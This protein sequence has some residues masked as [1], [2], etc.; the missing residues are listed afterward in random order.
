MMNLI[1]Q[2]DLLL[3]VVDLQT[4][5][6]QQLED[7]MAILAEHRL[8]PAHHRDQHPDS[9]RL[10]FVPVLVVVNKTDDNTADEEFEV[11]QELLGEAWSLLPISATTGRNLDELKQA[12]FD[13]LGIVRVYSKPPGKEPDFT[14]PFVL[15]QGGTVEEFAGKVHKDFLENLKFAR[16]WGSAVHDGQMVGRDHIL[17]DG[18]VVELRL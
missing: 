5:P 17:R 12:I 9:R 8:F 3:V 11:L 15:K 13:R 7:A 6:L 4:Y 2:T 14:A 16:I 1:R 10:T 18:D